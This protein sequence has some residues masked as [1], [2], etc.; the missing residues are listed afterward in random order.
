MAVNRSADVGLDPRQSLRE[1]T[2]MSDAADEQPI[3]RVVGTRVP[4]PIGAPPDAETRARTAT[5]AR[6][7]TR[8]PKGIFFYRNAEEMDRDRHRWTVDAIVATHKQRA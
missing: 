4:R 3:G 2:G 1:A 6:Y 7:L 8:A 5:N